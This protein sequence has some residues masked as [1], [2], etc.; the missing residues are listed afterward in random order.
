MVTPAHVPR[1][2]ATA[3]P[4]H[5]RLERVQAGQLLPL[6]MLVDVS[7]LTNRKAGPVPCVSKRV[8]AAPA[9]PCTVIGRLLKFTPMLPAPE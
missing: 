8:T 3:S 4:V 7:P 2:L 1:T 6:R 9:M 5:A